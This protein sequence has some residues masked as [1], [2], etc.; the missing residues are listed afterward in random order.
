MT[1]PRTF[2]LVYPNNGTWVVATVNLDGKE[3]HRVLID[4]PSVLIAVSIE[5]KK[6]EDKNGARS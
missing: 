5:M 3:T 1:E 6:L 2:I 4:E